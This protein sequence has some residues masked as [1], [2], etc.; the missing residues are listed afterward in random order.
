MQTHDSDAWQALADLYGPLIYAWGRRCGLS[1]DDAADVMQETFA[2]V[3]RNITGFSASGDGA[4]RGW[5]WTVTMNK[6][7][8]HARQHRDRPR[9]AGGTDMQALL[10]QLPE[11]PPD[12][13]REGPARRDQAALVHRALEQVQADFAPETWAAFRRSVLD[14]A[15]AATVASEAGITLN[16]LRQIRFRILR[17]LREQLAGFI[18]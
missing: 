2:A 9:A 4:F 18:E 16:N 7:R 11:Q 5:L 15:D 12:P 6:I 14:G 3:A 13:G 10:A 8:D 17:R 1:A